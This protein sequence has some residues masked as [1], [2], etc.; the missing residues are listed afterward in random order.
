[1]NNITAAQGL[2]ELKL[3][4]QAGSEEPQLEAQ[5]LLAHGLGQT[6][7]WLLAHPETELEPALWT[8]IQGMAKRRAKGKPLPYILGHWE[9]FGLTFSI[10]PAVLIPRPETELLV[11]TALAWLGKH[12][13]RRRAVDVGTGSGCIAVSLAKQVPDLCLTACDISA[14]ALWIARA[15]SRIHNVLDQI[16]LVQADLLTSFVPHSFDL[17]C[18]NL[19]YI[20]TDT[21]YE[22]PI[23]SYEPGLALDGGPDGLDLIR[24]LLADALRLLT[25]G[26]LLLLE[27]EHRQGQAVLDHILTSPPLQ[28]EGLEVG[29]FTGS[30]RLLQD[31]AHR[32][33][34]VAIEV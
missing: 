11:E 7:S 10:G 15:N 3:A 20:P 34:L 8:S 31:L 28:Y 17:I 22:L 24:R 5:L 9:F 21:L 23:Y 2:A 18:A 33:R 14:E 1:M 16:N 6:R 13:N 19:P 4:L 12:P 26:G 27:I 32:D 25:P 30:A 29:G